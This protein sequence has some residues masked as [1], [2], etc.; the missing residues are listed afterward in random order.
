[1]DTGTWDEIRDKLNLSRLGAP[2]LAGMAAILAVAVAAAV[3]ILAG[4]ATASD[5]EVQRSD[6]A[7]DTPVADE[8]AEPSTV[9]VHVSGAVRDPGL[10]ELADGSRVADAVQA[11][12]GFADDAAT[13]SCNLA[14]IVQD[15]E[16][17]VIATLGEVDE[18]AVVQD[19]GAPGGN[20]GLVN[21]NTATAAQLMELPG[22]GEATARKIVSD[23]EANGPFGSVAE[24]TRVSGVGEKKLAALEGMICV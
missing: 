11:A 23:R 4:S 3:F 18:G 6:D 14:R 8:P 19:G 16:H 15:G 20:S 9:F 1:M 13:D 24:L 22:I 5:F 21:I 12:G 17:I 10:H 2:A 7:L